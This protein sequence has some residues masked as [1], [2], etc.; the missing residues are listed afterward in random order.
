MRQMVFSSA[1]FLTLLYVLAQMKASGS[2]REQLILGYMGAFIS[3][4]FAAAPLAT[5]GN[6]I[7]KKTSDSLPFYLILLTNLVTLQWWM[8]GYLVGDNF[9]I[10]NNMFGWILSGFQLTLFVIYPSSSSRNQGNLKKN[11]LQEELL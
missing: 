3:V 7:Q 6:V 5:V 4:L 8:F 9:V 2:D 1:F 11:S 10:Y